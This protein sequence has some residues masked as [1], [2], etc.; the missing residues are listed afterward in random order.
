MSFRTSLSHH[1][2]SPSASRLAVGV[3][4]S[5]GELF[6]RLQGEGRLSEDRS[7]FYAA[8]LQRVPEH[9]H[10]SNVMTGLGGARDRERERERPNP[11]DAQDTER[12]R[13]LQVGSQFDEGENEGEH[14]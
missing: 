5:S 12:W 11:E 14:R 4:T 10:G 8:E 1:R 3:V 6:H 2:L 9:L 7:R 13:V